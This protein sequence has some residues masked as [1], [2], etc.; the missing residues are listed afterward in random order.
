[1]EKKS[2]KSHINDIDESKGIV[3]IYVSAFNNRDMKG[4]IIESKAFNKTVADFNSG[5]R[6]RLRHLYNHNPSI[7]LGLPVEISVDTKG[8]R[9][10]SHLNMGKQNVKDVFSDYMFMASHNNTLEHSI[11]FQPVNPRYDKKSNSRILSEIRLFEYSTIPFIG[12]NSETQVNEIKAMIKEGDYS[13]EKFL[14]LEEKVKQ[15]E[16]LIELKKPSADTLEDSKPSQTINQ[17]NIITH[18][19]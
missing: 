3:D 13:D 6:T 17:I 2:F 11:G 19:I 4:D 15:L 10:I 18:L 7:L 16:S 5:G 12:V 1:M 8:L 14:E 9:I